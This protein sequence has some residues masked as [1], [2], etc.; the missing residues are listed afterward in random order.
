MERDYTKRPNANGRWQL[1]LD[2]GTWYAID[3]QG[4]VNDAMRHG[5]TAQESRTIAGD[6]IRYL[7]SQ[8]PPRI[9]MDL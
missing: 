9:T 8:H 5:A 4:R 7:N 1:W 2:D 3:P 6:G